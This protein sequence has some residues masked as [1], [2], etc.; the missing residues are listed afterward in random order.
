MFIVTFAALQGLALLACAAWWRWGRRK[1]LRRRTE[2]RLT[3]PY[4]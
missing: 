1:T 4:R 2:P 3:G